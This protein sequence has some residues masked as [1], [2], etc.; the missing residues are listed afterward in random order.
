M[1]CSV[2]IEQQYRHYTVEADRQLFGDELFDGAARYYNHIGRMLDLGC[3]A[4][5]RQAPPRGLSCALQSI[6]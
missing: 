5:Y 2:S 4:V 6:R 1:R 3:G